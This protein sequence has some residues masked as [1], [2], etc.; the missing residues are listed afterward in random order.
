[1]IQKMM[2]LVLSLL[3][4]PVFAGVTIHC[5]ANKKCDVYLEN[6]SNSK[7][8]FSVFI[9]PQENSVTMGSTKIPADFSNA[10]EVSF[11]HI[12]YNFY[13]NK[14]EYSATLVNKTEVR[15]GWCKKVD[16]AW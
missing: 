1:M 15:Y 8:T 9:E 10:S 5:E 16:P 6:C 12:G 7:Y 3:S 2:F 13:I 14:Y 4:L 11:K